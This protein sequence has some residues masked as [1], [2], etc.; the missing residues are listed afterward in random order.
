[1]TTIPGYTVSEILAETKDAQVVS[2]K[3]GAERV[4]LRRPSKA[5]PYVSA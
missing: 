5:Y 4:L 2:A 1:M 3:H